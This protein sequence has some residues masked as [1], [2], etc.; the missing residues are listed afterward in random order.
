MLFAWP[1]PSIA[2]PAIADSVLVWGSNDSGQTSM[3]VQAQSGVT[4]IAAGE[5]HTVA[6][7]DD[8]SVVAWGLNDH[9]Q[10]TIPIAA[11]SGV[12]AIAEADRHRD[13]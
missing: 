3:P 11:Q 2:H 13:F 10:T 5:N 4:A 6:L 8:G 9:G 12:T 1:G 7:K